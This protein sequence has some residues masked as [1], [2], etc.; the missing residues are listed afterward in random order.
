MEYARK[1]GR[2]K[3]TA[4][5]KANILKFS[6]GLF[7]EVA[8]RPPRPTPTSSL[9]IASLTTCACSSCKSPSFTT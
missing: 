3:V 8:A 2:K 6:D 7:L 1:H 5:H 9:K 4:V